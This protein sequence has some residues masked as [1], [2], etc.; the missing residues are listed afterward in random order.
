[1]I[2]PVFP[3]IEAIIDIHSELLAEH[4]GAAGLRDRG[5]LEASL[6]RAH[7]I[8]AYADGPVALFD[9]AAA[10]CTSIC[11]NHPFVDGNKR[12]GFA[13]LGMILVLNGCYLD[14]TEREA[15]EIMLAVAAGTLA[16]KL[17]AQW[18]AKNSF[19]A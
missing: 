5:S 2:D 11:R 15:A 3:P 12:A 16:E 14:V 18:V 1:M 9:L 17:F 13:A 4:G 10:V 6:A 8:V 7:Q 19:E